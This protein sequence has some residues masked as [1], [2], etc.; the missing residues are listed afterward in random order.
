MLQT[1]AIDYVEHRAG[2]R[3]YVDFAGDRLEIVDVTTA[4]VRKV[5]VFVAILPCSAYYTYREA[6]VVAEKGGPDKAGMRERYPFPYGEPPCAIVPD[7]LKSAVA[8]QRPQRSL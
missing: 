6:C 5:E 1:N 7:N 3:M 8:E 4:E 2:D